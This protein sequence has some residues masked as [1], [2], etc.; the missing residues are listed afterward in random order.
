M[1]KVWEKI[2]RWAEK[3]IPETAVKL[4]YD[5]EAQRGIIFLVLLIALGIIGLTGLALNYL[6]SYCEYPDPYGR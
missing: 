5:P 2:A 4:K 1:H 6:G 3:D